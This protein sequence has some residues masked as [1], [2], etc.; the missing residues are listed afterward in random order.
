MSKKHIG[1]YVFSLGHR[2]FYCW[3]M[4]KNKKCPLYHEWTFLLHTTL[5]GFA[6]SA[7]LFSGICFM[8]ANGDTV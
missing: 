3:L 6:V 2:G 7:F 1:R 8:S 5:K 4:Y